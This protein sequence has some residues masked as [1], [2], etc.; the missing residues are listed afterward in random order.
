MQNYMDYVI[1][2]LQCIF[3]AAS[4]CL[5]L[6]MSLCMPYVCIVSVCVFACISTCTL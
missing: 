4:G 3:A 5:C 6:V 1:S 2:N